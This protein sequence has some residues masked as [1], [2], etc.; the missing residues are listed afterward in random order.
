MAI[1]FKS[2]KKKIEQENKELLELINEKIVNSAPYESRFE[3]LGY[4]KETDKSLFDWLVHEKSVGI[5]SEET[6]GDYLRLKLT[7]NKDSVTTLVARENVDNFDEVFYEL[8]LN[9]MSS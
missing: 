7:Y 1:K 2:K 5:L 3:D 4:N 6:G 9:L 8:I